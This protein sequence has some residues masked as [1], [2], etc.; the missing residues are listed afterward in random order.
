DS[1]LTAQPGQVGGYRADLRLS[2]RGCEGTR[3][4][5]PGRVLRQGH[6]GAGLVLPSGDRG[7]DELGVPG[8]GVGGDGGPAEGT[9]PRPQPGG[10][11]GPD[12][13]GRTGSTGCRTRTT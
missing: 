4:V 12:R 1:S 7:R 6:A 5:G 11:P 10:N 2:S 13:P 9:R 8:P 3:P